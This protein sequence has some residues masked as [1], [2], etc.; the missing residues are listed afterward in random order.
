M[1]RAQHQV[2]GLGGSQSQ[3]D[4]LQVAHFTDQ[5]D[6]RVFAQRRAQRFGKAQRVA[7][8]LTLVDQAL[9]RGVHELDRIFNRQD[10]IRAVLVAMVE[11]AGERGRLARTGRP[12]DQ[13]QS[14][15]Q[16]AQ[17]TKHPRRMQFV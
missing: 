3:A 1:Q 13:H 4:G 7:M 12:G 8:D 10:V 15:R 2:A 9:L 14:S 16:H 6:V 11:H 5:D 17:V